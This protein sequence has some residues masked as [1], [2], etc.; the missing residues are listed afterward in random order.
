MKGFYSEMIQ[1]INEMIEK[2]EEASAL[3]KIEEELS[4]PYIP[5]DFQQA[6]LALKQKLRPER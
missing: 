1:E 5:L 3:N 6:I 2:G 4:M